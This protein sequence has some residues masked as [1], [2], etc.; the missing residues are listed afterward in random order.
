M[1]AAQCD[2][3]AVC[4]LVLLAQHSP[5][6]HIEANSILKKLFKSRSDKR[7]IDNPSAFIHGCCKNAREKLVLTPAARPPGQRT[8]SHL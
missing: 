1:I 8:P 2:E 7:A 4:E 5:E 6:G 3:V